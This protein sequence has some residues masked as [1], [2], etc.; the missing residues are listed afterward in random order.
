M[1]PRTL[2]VLLVL[3][4]AIASVGISTVTEPNQTQGENI[5]LQATAHSSLLEQHIAQGIALIRNGEQRGVE[6]LKMGRL[7]AQLAVDYKN[8]GDFSRAGSAY[9]RSLKLLESAPQGAIDYAIV[10]DNLSSLYL[11]TGDF[12]AAERCSR[13]SLTVRESLGDKL[14][15]ARGEGHLAEVELNRRRFK[16]ARQYSLKAYNE[17]ISLRDHET[18][19]VVK[20]LITL[21]YSECFEGGCPNGLVHAREAVSLACGTYSA[22]SIQVGQARLAL[23]LAEWKA[24][25]T[26]GPDAEMRDS[27]EILKARMPAGHP[28]VV[29]A[30]EQ[31][32]QY[33]DAMH[34]GPEAKRVAQEE[35]QLKELHKRASYTV[36]VHGLQR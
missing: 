28:Y 25:M 4:R 33:L 22:D 1:K 26:Y 36:S 21:I 15:I 13:R 23:G 17:M 31:Y 16:D 19:D 27:I 35:V 14:Q 5:E 8:Q 10:L 24:G 6:P 29:G 9:N 30:M 18:D 3:A 34:R 2:S 11:L 32:R 12:E 20:T 7:W